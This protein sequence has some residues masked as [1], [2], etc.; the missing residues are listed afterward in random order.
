[1]GINCVGPPMAEI[2]VVFIFATYDNLSMK[3]EKK[4]CYFHE[5]LEITFF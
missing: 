4:W 1:M 5:T 2:M 3:W